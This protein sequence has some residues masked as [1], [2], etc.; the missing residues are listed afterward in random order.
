MHDLRKMVGVWA[1]EGSE[2]SIRIGGLEASS[3][4]DHSACVIIEKASDEIHMWRRRYE[5]EQYMEGSIEAKLENAENGL[6]EAWDR[7]STVGKVA[8]EL[9]E[10]CTSA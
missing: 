1:K 7:E 6:Q 4:S 3:N 5:D 9:K 8:R 2:L 10:E